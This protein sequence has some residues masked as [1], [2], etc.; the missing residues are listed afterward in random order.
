M[1]YFRLV[2]PTS[3][4]SKDT[5]QTSNSTTRTWNT[6]TNIVKYADG[7]KLKL[8]NGTFG[9]DDRYIHSLGSPLRG[10]GTVRNLLPRVARIFARAHILSTLGWIRAVPSALQENRIKRVPR[11][12]SFLFE[13]KQ[14]EHPKT[15]TLVGP[16]FSTH[17]LQFGS[18]SPFST[19]CMRISVV[20][21]PGCADTYL[22]ELR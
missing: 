18:L 20:T 5:L 12:S 15:G 6:R 4:K 9:I 21:K 8:T 16:S 2:S 13:K 22:R 10:F 14:T 3:N 19:A 17:L 11:E 1:E 7:M